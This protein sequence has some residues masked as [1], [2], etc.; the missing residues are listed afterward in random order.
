MVKR[1]FFVIQIIISLGSKKKYKQILS[2][3][4]NKFTTNPFS[5]LLV[6]SSIYSISTIS[7][8]YDIVLYYTIVPSL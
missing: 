2:K 5:T 6:G 7:S 8:I 1:L 3:K 4:K